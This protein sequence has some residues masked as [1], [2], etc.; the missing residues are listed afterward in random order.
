MAI[1]GEHPE[2]GLSPRVRGNRRRPRAGPGVSGSIPA[3]AGEPLAF[4]AGRLVTG[5]YPRVCGGT[6]NP[7]LQSQPVDGLSPRV[8]GNHECPDSLLNGMRSIPACAGEPTRWRIHVCGNRVYPRVCGGTENRPTL[9]SIWCGLSPRVRGNPFDRRCN[10]RH[11]GS[12]PACAGEPLRWSAPGCARK[13]YPRVCGGTDRMSPEVLATHGLSPRV[14]GNPHLAGVI[15]F[16]CGSIPAC[17][18]EP[19]RPT[20][21]GGR[22]RVYPRVCGGTIGAHSC[23]CA[24]SGLSPRVRGNHRRPLLPVRPFRSIPACAGEPS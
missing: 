12:I 3:C 11:R 23:Q 5:V 1:C 10:R 8:R 15:A 20:A 16:R 21:R 14:R 24:H 13:V 2:D 17:A 7:L 22:Q 9:A 18:G 4:H 19:P 6:L